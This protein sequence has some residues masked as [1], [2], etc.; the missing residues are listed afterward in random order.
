MTLLFQVGCAVAIAGAVGAGVFGLPGQADQ[1]EVQSVS[2]PGSID[3]GAQ[4][5]T[6]SKPGSLPPVSRVDARSISDRLA[7]LDNAPVV[8][9]PEA[10]TDES[11]PEAP[12]DEG[13]DDSAAIIKRVKYLGY[14]TEGDAPLAFIKIDSAQ[15]IVREQAIVPAGSE[16]LDDLEVVAIRPN[17]IVLTDGEQRAKIRLAS[18]TGPAIATT[19]GDEI[20]SRPTREQDVVLTPEELESIA[21]LPPRQR[22]VRERLLK[23]QKIGRPAKPINMTPKAEYRASFSNPENRTGVVRNDDRTRSREEIEREREDQE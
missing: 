15:R 20:D 4:G 1:G 11:A 5:G 2:T 19:G 7:L 16:G 3:A 9:E 10:T 8:Q 13:Q 18:R 12:T 6:Q 22:A 21:H 14:I 23:R 17:F